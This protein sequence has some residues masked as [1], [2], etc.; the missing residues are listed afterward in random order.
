MR[1]ADLLS[2]TSPLSIA[3]NQ[4]FAPGQLPASRGVYEITFWFRTSAGG[5]FTYQRGPIRFDF[6]VGVGETFVT[7]RVSVPWSPDRLQRE[8]KTYHPT[9]NITGSG[10]VSIAGEQVRK[11]EQVKRK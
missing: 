5:G 3:A 6:T 2:G 9:P 4:L 7:H 1:R 8:L 10:W 11:V